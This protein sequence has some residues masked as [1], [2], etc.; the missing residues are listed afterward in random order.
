M[1]G[2]TH[3]CQLQQCIMYTQHTSTNCI[4]NMHYYIHTYNKSNCSYIAMQIAKYLPQLYL[5]LV[6]SHSSS[7]QSSV[8]IPPL[9]IYAL[10]CMC[11][12]QFMH[13]CYVSTAEYI[14]FG[15]YIFK[16]SQY[17]QGVLIFQV[18]LCTKGLI[19]IHNY[20]AKCMD[21]T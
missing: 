6:I 15:Y 1:L 5:E 19:C 21:D 9:A 7:F 3:T 14:W 18:T 17:H 13:V 11:I 8:H 2:H 4:S 20:V 12:S 16:T 10:L